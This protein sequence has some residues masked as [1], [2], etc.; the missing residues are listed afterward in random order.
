MIALTHLG[1]GVFQWMLRTSWQAAVLAGLILLAQWLLRN[2]LPPFWRYGLWLFL[3]VNWL[4]A[5]LQVLH[6]FNPVLWLAWARMRADRELATDALALAHVRESDHAPYGE[7]IL[8]VLEGLTGEP[9]LPGLVGIVENKAQIKER[10]TAISRPRKYWKWAARAAVALV[11]GMGLTGA[12]REKG[13]APDAAGTL[14]PDLTGRVQLTNGQPMKATVFISTAGPKVGTSPFCPSCYADCRKSASTDSQGQ[15][16][17]ESLDPQL[18][19]RILVVGEGLRPKF[20]EHVN[21]AKGPISVS[22]EPQLL[23]GVPP[24]LILRGRVVDT[25]GAPVEGA[26]V[27]TLGYHTSDGRG[28]W[29]EFEGLDP[30]AV[31]D[32]RGNFLITSRKEFASLDLKIEARG[33]ANRMF[34]KVRGD[35]PTPNLQLTEGAAITGRVMLNG[36]PLANVAVG[37]VSEDRALENFTGDFEVGTD[38]DGRFAFVN[39]PPNVRYHVYGQMKALADHGTTG[40]AVVDAGGDGSTTNVG[41]LVVGRANRLSGRVVLKDGKTIP[42]KTQLIVSREDAWD[43][44]LVDLDKDGSFNVSGIP[45]EAISLSV[46]V[47]G[48]RFSIKNESLDLQNPFRLIGRI[49]HDITNLMILLEY[50]GM[51]EP[52]TVPPGSGPDSAPLR[53]AERAYNHASQRIISGRVTDKQTGEPIASFRVTPGRPDE[54]LGERLNPQHAIAGTNGSFVIY[55]DDQTTEFLLRI[56]APEY[57]PMSSRELAPGLT[58][59]DF[60]LTKRGGPSDVVLLGNQAGATRSK[61]IIDMP[62]RDNNAAESDSVKD[63]D[64]RRRIL[65]GEGDST[66]RNTPEAGATLAANSEFVKYMINP[67]WIKQMTYAEWR[68]YVSGG[69]PGEINSIKWQLDTNLAALQPSGYFEQKLTLGFLG[70]SLDKTGAVEMNV[71]GVSED[72]YWRAYSLNHQLMLSPRKESEGACESNNPQLLS[73]WREDHLEKIR[74]FGLPALRPNS[75]NL[76]ND[77]G[78]SATTRDG[79]SV[80]GKVLTTDAL[81][82]MTLLYSVEGPPIEVFK[83]SYRYRSTNMLPSYIEVCKAGSKDTPPG[84]LVS[85]VSISQVE[86][87]IDPN[88]SAGY[89]PSQFYPDMQVFTWIEEWKN[90]QRYMVNADGGFIEVA[91]NG[92]LVKVAKAPPRK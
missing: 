92:H 84:D 4:V 89:K 67:P 35:A 5:L 37:L 1:G 48:Y 60:A 43:S 69:E 74:H 6:W 23:A 7:T 13:G 62:V 53:G 87:G 34:L 79:K 42:P 36:K 63:Q 66:L 86:Y 22:L 54:I 76:G 57:A 30:L 41:D 85:M 11:A 12:Q 28:S 77:G 19:F 9:A 72:F 78:F 8:K 73:S 26:A 14:R 46:A 17:I 50:G 27:E 82:P 65:I 33:F 47:P 90:G 81:R 55:F 3:A 18:I 75:F 15:F 56:E 29:G 31:T 25:K 68:K 70:T 32:A 71:Y 24:Q 20:V 39:M 61:F 21:P 44:L 64:L 2:R 52:Q 49:D 16:K 38:A 51:L 80:H 45:N 59:Y 88:G 40:I 91:P 58:E 83:V 10:L